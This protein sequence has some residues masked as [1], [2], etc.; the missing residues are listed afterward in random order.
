M[1][2]Y[3]EA[4]DALATLV[5]ATWKAEYPTVPVFH[6]NTKQIPLDSIGHN[7]LLV[8]ITF[9]DTVR[10]GIDASPI[11]ASHGFITLRIFSKEGSGVRTGLA[12]QDYLTSSLKYQQISGVTLDCPTPGR[13]Q[14]QT[15]WA[16]VDLKVPF[17]F[18]Q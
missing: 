8:A 15:G 1:T 9:N 13:T 2:T 14:V 5:D 7:F 10:T 3:V 6:E 16:S 18:W 12:M 17:S 4:R 11:S